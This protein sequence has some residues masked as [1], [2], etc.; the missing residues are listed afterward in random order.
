MFNIIIICVFYQTSIGDPTPLDII[1]P[2]PNDALLE[3]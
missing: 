2:S 1:F 3:S